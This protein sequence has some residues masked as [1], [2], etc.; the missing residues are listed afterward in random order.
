MIGAIASD[1]GLSASSEKI[2]FELAFFTLEFFDLPIQPGDPLQGI[3]MAT[4]LIASILAEL[5]FLTVQALNF[6]SQFSDFLA[7]RLHQGN[8]RRGGITAATELHQLTIHDY[9]GLPEMTRNERGWSPIIQI[10][11]AT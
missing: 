7:Q 3:A 4:S 5:V 1:R 11:K 10:R 9:L 8:Q 2:G 6:G